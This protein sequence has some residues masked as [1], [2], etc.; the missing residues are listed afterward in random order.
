LCW[1]RTDRSLASCFVSI[2]NKNYSNAWSHL[3]TKHKQEEYPKLCSSATIV[4]DSEKAGLGGMK[5]NLISDFKSEG[6]QQASSK[7]ALTHLYRFFNDANIAIDQSNN[8]NLRQFVSYIIDN[9]SSLRQRKTECYFSKYKYK[10]YEVE[11][12]HD[13]LNL[14][15]KLIAYTREHYNHNLK[16]KIPFLYVAH[17]GWDSNDYDILGVSIH[18]VLPNSWLPISL[19]VGLQ[20]ISSKKSDYTSKMILECLER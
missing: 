6:F 3:Q 16:T 17:D 19:S 10:K 13:F 4:V 9:A 5:Q 18:F 15:R 12:F 8:N 2:V 1:Q 20:R 7:I 14:L 11:V